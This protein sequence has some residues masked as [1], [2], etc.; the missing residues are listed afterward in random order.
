MGQSKSKDVSNNKIE[1][2]FVQNANPERQRAK[3]QLLRAKNSKKWRKKQQ[4]YSLPCGLDEIGMDEPSEVVGSSRSSNPIVN[5]KRRSSFQ[6]DDVLPS[7]HLVS[8]NKKKNLPHNDDKDLNTFSNT[9][10]DTVPSF[11]SI[12]N[13]IHRK[14]LNN[15]T[16]DSSNS[17]TCGDYTEEIINDNEIMYSLPVLSSLD[18][19]KHNDHYNSPSSTLHHVPP[20]VQDILNNGSAP[21]PFL[22]I[23]EEQTTPVLNSTIKSSFD[24]KDESHY[25]SL[26]DEEK[27]P[28]M[29]FIHVEIESGPCLE[30]PNNLIVIQPKV[31]QNMH[32]PPTLNSTLNKEEEERAERKTTNQGRQFTNSAEGATKEEPGVFDRF[33]NKIKTLEL[34]RKQSFAIDSSHCLPLRDE[35]EDDCDESKYSK[36][37]PN[38]DITSRSTNSYNYSRGSSSSSESD[39]YTKEKEDQ[40]FSLDG[41]KEED[42]TIDYD[43]VIDQAF[44]DILMDE[45]DEEHPFLLS[46]SKNMQKRLPPIGCSSD[47]TGEECYDSLDE[48]GLKTGKN[49]INKQKN[50]T[51]NLV[52]SA[53]SSNKPRRSLPALPKEALNYSS[54]SERAIK[55]LKQKIPSSYN[56]TISHLDNCLISSVRDS[57]EELRENHGSKS[58]KNSSPESLHRDSGCQSLESNNFLP[59][60]SLPVISQSIDSPGFLWVELDSNKPSRE[61][62]KSR[63]TKRVERTKSLSSYNTKKASNRHS[64]PPGSFKD[65]KFKKEIVLPERKPNLRKNNSNKRPTSAKPLVRSSTSRI[66]SAVVTGINTTT[67]SVTVEWRE[68]EETKGKEIELETLLGLNQD[69]IPPPPP[70][71]N[72]AVITN[73]KLPK[74]AQRPTN[75]NRNTTPS[76]TSQNTNV[77]SSGV[78]NRNRLTSRQTM[79]IP[80]NEE[81]NPTNVVVPNSHINNNLATNGHGSENAPPS[82]SSRL[83]QSTTPQ[84][85]YSSN[86][87]STAETVVKAGTAA[88]AAAGGDRRRSNVVKE[89]ERLKKNREERRAKQ[90]E[91]LEEKE[92]QKN[93][94]PGNPNWEFLCM[95]RDYQEQLEFNPFHDGDTITDHQITVCVRKRPLNKKEEKRREV[96]VVTM[97][98]KDQIIVH[99]PKTKVD[100][101]KYLD[102]QHFRYDYA[103]DDTATNEL[104]YKYAARPLVQ[105]IFEGGMATCFAYGQTGSGKTH[106]MGGEFH[107]KSQD[108]KNGIYA[109]AT[110]DV[111][112]FLKSPKYKGL[113]LH[114]SCSYFE[115]YSGKVFDLLS[116]KS[117]LRVLE[118][119]KQQVVI[120]GL[121]EKVVECVEDVLKLITH[122]N[123][124]RTSGQTSANAHSSRSHAV[125]QIILRQNKNK[126]FGKFS[127]IDLAGNERGADTHS[128]DRQ[129]RMEGAEINKSLLALKECIR[130]LGRK[131]GH[132]PF[133]ASKLTQVLRDSF[134]GEK[135]KTCMIAMVSPV[136]SSCEHTLNTLRYADRVKELGAND[137]AN[138]L[139]N[140]LANNNPPPKLSASPTEEVV[141]TRMEDG[142]LSPEDSDLAQL[143]SMNEGELSADWYNFQEAISHLQILEEDLVENHRSAI[144]RMSHWIEEDASL[145]AVTNGVDYDQDAY[146]HQLEEMIDEKIQVLSELKEKARNFLECQIDEEAMS[147]KLF[148]HKN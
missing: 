26:K 141:E 122:G 73:N 118:D 31:S 144:N 83:P 97:P 148:L 59:P 14:S 65:F 7:V 2:S 41:D 126:L 82:S 147:R 67:K 93:V 5:I 68:R 60:P 94:D 39:I 92:A 66:H 64:A 17:L 134:M 81:S 47:E 13:L 90:A 87:G 58:N 96:D 76:A 78:R 102:N 112:K 63:P 37:M 52:L 105:N 12:K 86:N 123:N 18:L 51:P 57:L 109:L 53:K 71:T 104:V 133:R 1:S 135:S 49:K 80:Q 131:G 6:W 43:E 113:K 61:T 137:P 115:I 143:R 32:S 44:N 46:E 136:L 28:P 30:S 70:P 62:L 56:N 29:A 79:G 55:V 27:L 36:S 132:L 139:A 20:R 130:A 95:I 146:C 11:N 128:A 138:N 100:L 88:A 72:G 25:L 99:E 110:M 121:T 15:K 106:T 77:V 21:V 103:F 107:G 116:G 101:T 42:T 140:N 114:V 74:Y 111:F 48:D 10:G 40:I 33:D 84:L 142:V 145:I 117:K 125:F 22:K 108:S 50:I 34:I 124:L 24:S 98:N 8:Y 129:T 35:S 69:L 38:F 75:N 89:V 16:D 9:R 119:G 127:L 91:I 85:N 23:V 54:V 4:G 3:K 120:V 45:E 19:S